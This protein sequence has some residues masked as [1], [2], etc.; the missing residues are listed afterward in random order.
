MNI[1]TYFKIRRVKKDLRGFL[2]HLAHIMHVNDDILADATKGNLQELLDEG[3]AQDVTNETEISSFL[4]SAQLRAIKILPKKTHPIIR[5]YVDIFAVALTV[6]FGLRALYMQPF[7]IPTSSMQPTLFGIHYI[8]DAK[9]PDGS[10]T[11]PD[12]PSPIQYAL[13]STQRAKIDI[14]R[15]GKLDA[16]SII[17]YNR[18]IIFTW[19]K[20]NIG[21]L[22]YHLPGSFFNHVMKYCKM[23]D[24][25]DIDTIAQINSGKPDIYDCLKS[26]RPYIKDEQLCN[27]WL[28]LGDHLFVDRFTFQFRDPKRGDITVFTTNGIP[29]GSKGY[30]YIKRLIGMPGDTLEIVDNMVHVKEKGADLFKPIT[31]FNIPEINRIYSGKGGYHGHIK[32]GLLGNENERF[33]T[34]ARILSLKPGVEFNYSGD[35]ELVIPEDCYFMMGDNSA[36]SHDGRGWGFVPRKNIIGRAFFVFWPFSRRWGTTDRMPP[37]DLETNSDSMSLQ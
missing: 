30:F 21:G 2:K 28:S 33:F 26:M 27:G 13:F 31:S 15:A 29:T 25:F 23:N 12:L 37:L 10:N 32:G 4:K 16:S 34:I 18:N 1:F 35:G 6:A 22:E 36:H 20:F 5:E 8:A 14:K 19:S 9:L 17:E 24:K 7:K 11:L 3:Y